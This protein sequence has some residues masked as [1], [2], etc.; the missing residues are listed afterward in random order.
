MASGSGSD[1][2]E[3]DVQEQ[4]VSATMEVPRAHLALS[5]M[6]EW[7]PPPLRVMRSTRSTRWN[8]RWAGFARW[9]CSSTGS[10]TGAELTPRVGQIARRADR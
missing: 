1:A 2:Q 9:S 6:I 3:Q 5:G 8:T 10:P 7:A 4:L